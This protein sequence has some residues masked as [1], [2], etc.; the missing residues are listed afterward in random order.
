MSLHAD[1]R[2]VASGTCRARYGPRDNRVEAATR[3][4]GRRRP[5]RPRDFLALFPPS[6]Y[7]LSR[8]FP[9]LDTRAWSFLLPLR[10]LSP[11]VPRVVEL[12][13][14]RSFVFPRRELVNRT[15]V[16][17]R[18][19]WEAV[20]SWTRG[21]SS[22]STRAGWAWS[23]RRARAACPYF[24]FSPSSSRGPGTPGTPGSAGVP[25]SPLT[26]LHLHRA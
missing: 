19:L 15:G 8:Y 3:R 6:L 18:P 9:S 22:R 21:M 12:D 10:L 24:P 14:I 2:D 25:V 23:E 11:Y 17:P 13:T 20:H 7:L 26:F 4:S 16:S 1:G 5:R